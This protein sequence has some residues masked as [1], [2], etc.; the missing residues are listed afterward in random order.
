MTTGT[1]IH[2]PVTTNAP[3]EKTDVS[4]ERRISSD[5]L[6]ETIKRFNIL[7]LQSKINDSADYRSNKNVAK[8]DPKRDPLVDTHTSDRK[9][10]K[11]TDD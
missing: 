10:V 6:S 7:T 11:I 8:S 5:S 4:N 9:K 3:R 1:F 2:I